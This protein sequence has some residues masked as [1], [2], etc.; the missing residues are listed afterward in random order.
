MITVRRALEAALTGSRAVT[1]V[2]V[3]I[4]AGLRAAVDAGSQAWLATPRA[5]GPW[6]GRATPSDAAL[7]ID[8][9]NLPVRQRRLPGTLAALRREAGAVRCVLA[10]GHPDRV[11]TDVR[12]LCAE[13]GVEVLPADRSPNTADRA[14]LAAALRLYAGG[15][16]RWWIASND[17][18]FSLLPG[19]LTVLST[20]SGQPAR[21]LVA[22]ATEVRRVGQR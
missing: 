4:D 18:A 3:G 9:D 5:P 16:R 12:D 17:A 21:A 7:L 20:G 13:V 2:A 6:A 19:E 22:A 8:L 1:A 15:V 11:T 10:A 14:L